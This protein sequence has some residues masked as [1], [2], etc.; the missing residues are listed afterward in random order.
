LRLCPLRLCPL[1][2]WLSGAA[3]NASR[4]LPTA[5]YKCG[6]RRRPKSYLAEES[7][8]EEPAHAG[9]FAN[10]TRN[11]DWNH[12]NLLAGRFLFPRGGFRSELAASP[13]NL[14]KSD[15]DAK[16]GRTPKMRSTLR[17]SWFL[18]AA[19]L[20][21]QANAI[22]FRREWDR[23]ASRQEGICPAEGWTRKSGPQGIYPTLAAV[24]HRARTCLRI[25]PWTAPLH[26]YAFAIAAIW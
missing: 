3:K 17:A 4:A 22:G 24:R 7:V 13:R 21:L 25:R 2:L 16:T 8:Q 14:V 5:T 20:A 18:G 10:H 1:R 11:S 19:T 6:I 26:N 9:T 23:A 15:R 12:T